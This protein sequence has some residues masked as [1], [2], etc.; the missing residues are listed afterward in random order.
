MAVLPPPALQAVLRTV[1]P[2]LDEAGWGKLARA[3]GIERAAFDA[4]HA[5]SAVAHA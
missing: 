2:H 4:V 5:S 1:R 3:V